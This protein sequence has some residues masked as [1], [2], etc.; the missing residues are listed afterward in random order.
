MKNIIADFERTIQEAYGQ[1]A[2][3]TEAE[4]L[5]SSSEGKWSGKELIGHLIDSASNNH[6]RFVRIQLENNLSLPKYEQE[7]WVA[8][9]SYQTESWADLLL[10]WKSYNLHLLHVISCIPEDKL[11]NQCSV[12]NAEPVTLKFLVEDYVVHLKHHLKQLSGLIV[13]R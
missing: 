6:Q 5:K 12:G 9:Q 13:E 10:F 7:A 8:C 1:L 2:K 11:N 3:V 4:S